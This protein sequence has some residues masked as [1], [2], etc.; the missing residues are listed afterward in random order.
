MNRDHEVIQVETLAELL[1]IPPLDHDSPSLPA[2]E[3]EKALLKSLVLR[4]IRRL[5]RHSTSTGVATPRIK[6]KKR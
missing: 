6:R 3:E 1:G 5:K 2:T 4:E